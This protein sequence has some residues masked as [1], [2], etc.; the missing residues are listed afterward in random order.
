VASILLLP[1]WPLAAPRS[2]TTQIAV[3]NRF[4]SS[5]SAVVVHLVE[6]CRYLAK[7]TQGS[8]LHDGI[9]C[10]CLT[11]DELSGH[12]R[13]ACLATAAAMAASP[14]GGDPP[15]STRSAPTL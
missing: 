14:S 15:R 11:F 1:T 12:S 6:D 2:T 4:G 3:V 10:Y 8:S 5:T 7:K 9:F 13:R